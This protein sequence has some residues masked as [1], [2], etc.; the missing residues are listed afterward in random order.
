MLNR[1]PF[2][3]I[4]QDYGILGVSHRRGHI[5]AVGSLQLEGSKAHYLVVN[6]IIYPTQIQP[7]TAAHSRAAVTIITMAALAKPEFVKANISTLVAVGLGMLATLTAH[8][9]LIGESMQQDRVGA[10]ICCWFAKHVWL[11]KHWLQSPQRRAQ[12]EFLH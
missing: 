9:A 7:T 10:M 8:H 3:Y 12:G 5:R 6:I 2:I 1:S 4:D 11:S